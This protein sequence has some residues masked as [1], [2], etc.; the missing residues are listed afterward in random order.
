MGVCPLAS[1]RTGCLRGPFPKITFKSLTTS[2]TSSP[3]WRLGL[4][5]TSTSPLK[6]LPFFLNWCLSGRNQRCRRYTTFL[7]LSKYVLLVLPKHCV[8]ALY[9]LF[10]CP[11]R[12]L[13]AGQSL[14]VTN[15]NAQVEISL[16]CTHPTHVHLISA[17]AVE[18]L[19]LM[20]LGIHQCH[21]RVAS[22]LGWALAS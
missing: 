14:V 9:P 15:N 4:L 1:F 22:G 13:R 8:R 16:V 20:A 5:R 18:V 17:I 21:C 7:L 2:N 6:C 19:Q 3:I 12:L 11:E 10:V